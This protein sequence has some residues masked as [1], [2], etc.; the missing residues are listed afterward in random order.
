MPIRFTARPAIFCEAD[1]PLILKC[2]TLASAM[3]LTLGLGYVCRPLY[4]P[5]AVHPSDSGNERNI[6]DAKW[7]DVG[8]LVKT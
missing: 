8:G 4:D 6:G 3:T 1:A 7:R 2:S 5:V